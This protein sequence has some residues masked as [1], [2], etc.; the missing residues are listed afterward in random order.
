MNDLLTAERFAEIRHDLP[1]SGRRTELH[2][3]VV[4]QL[5]TLDVPHGNCIL[6]LSKAL[7]VYFARQGPGLTAYACY[8]LGLI[9]T[10]QPDT[11]LFPA[12]SCF[13]SGA[14]FAESDNVVTLTRPA[15][16]IDVPPT[17]A[18]LRQLPVRM[19]QFLDW[20][21]GLGWGLDPINKQVHIFR[22]GE[23]A[24]TLVET[25]KLTCPPDQSELA[26]FSTSVRELFAEP[27]WWRK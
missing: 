24:R 21:V 7:A 18:R 20:G 27:V 2:A 19:Q 6:N 14:P 23:P 10:R 11:V 25:E 4:V 3:G 22:A 17:P 26:G 1:D 13:D 9:L 15:L 12:I 16:V 5:P 8:D